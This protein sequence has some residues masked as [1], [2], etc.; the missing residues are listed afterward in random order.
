LVDEGL[1][2]D[3]P[4]PAPYLSA[5]M[6][7]RL[8][9]SGFIEPCLPSPAEHPPSGTDWVHEIKHDG[10]RLMVRR[11]ASHAGTGRPRLIL[12]AAMLRRI[13]FS[14]AAALLLLALSTPVTQA[15]R[16]RVTTPISF[17]VAASGGSDSNDCLSND[18]PCATMQG[19]YDKIK[20]DYDFTTGI[21]PKRF[22]GRR[23]SGQGRRQSE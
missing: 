3:S 4:A 15:Q 20:A 19:A 7:L 14:Y 10:Y 23:L 22:A 16:T 2:F 11:V 5:A 21:S 13:T 8:R 9:P 6:L 17:Y 12:R 18:K 1:R